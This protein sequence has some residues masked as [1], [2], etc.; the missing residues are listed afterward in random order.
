M[1][2]RAFLAPR[3]FGVF[4]EHVT[5]EFVEQRHSRSVMRT[6]AAARYQ[7]AGAATRF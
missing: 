6:T 1:N 5:A 3:G 2:V 4:G 7:G